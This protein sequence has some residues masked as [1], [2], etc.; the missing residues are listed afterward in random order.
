VTLG[1]RVDDGVLHASPEP[2]PPARA[3]A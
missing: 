3:P 1:W 2:A